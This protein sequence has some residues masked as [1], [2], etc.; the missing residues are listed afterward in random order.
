[1][2]SLKNMSKAE[3]IAVINNRTATEAEVEDL[4]ARITKARKYYQQQRSEIDGLQKLLDAA[5]PTV[6]H[7]AKRVLTGAA[8]SASTAIK[9]RAAR[10][11]DAM[12]KAKAAA[13]AGGHAVKVEFSE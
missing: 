3:L 5:N 7:K 2:K 4:K 10:A 9:N 8:L 13:I 6:T 1:M 11:R 12:A